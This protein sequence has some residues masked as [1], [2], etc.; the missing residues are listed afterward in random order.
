M[1]DGLNLFDDKA[2]AVGGFPMVFRG[3]ERESVDAYIADLEQRVRA[4]RD[5][6]RRLKQEAELKAATEGDTDFSRLGAHATALLA[7]AERQAAELVAKAGVEA[8]RLR[9]SAVSDATAR[10]ELVETE[11]TSS[12]EEVHATLHRLRVEADERAASQVAAAQGNAEQILT[13]ARDRAATII[14]TAEQRADDIR[15]TA[16]LDAEAMVLAAKEEAAAIR[17]KGIAEQTQAL[18]LLRAKHDEVSRL[19]ADAL[20]ESEKL[21]AASTE[22]LTQEAQQ[23]AALRAKAIAD[24]EQIRHMAHK[25]AD[26]RAADAAKA[27]AAKAERLERN[28]VVR[29]DT[30]ERE[31]SILTTRKEAVVAQLEALATLAQEGGRQFIDRQSIERAADTAAPAVT[32]TSPANE[33][34]EP[35]VV[36]PEGKPAPDAPVADDDAPATDD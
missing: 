35:T 21:Q 23:A 22:R 7:A 3:Y 2:S 34:A 20:A 24:A 18:A 33:E 36:L 28:H 31:V 27:A 15:R 11:A 25:A 30:L 19:T 32:R 26:E 5:E 29:R 8:D 4:A 10:R 1:S 14:A 16:R 6:A 13:S 17:A 9:A 12:R